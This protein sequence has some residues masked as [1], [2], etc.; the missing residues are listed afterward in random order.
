[1]YKR[2]DEADQFPEVIMAATS[3][4]L[5]YAESCRDYWRMEDDR[6]WGTVK[7][8]MNRKHTVGGNVL[9]EMATVGRSTTLEKLPENRVTFDES[10]KE[11][12]PDGPASPLTP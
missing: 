2:Q 4:K 6:E 10:I 8:K 1:M 12:A 9:K 7:P 5:A 3:G 11:P